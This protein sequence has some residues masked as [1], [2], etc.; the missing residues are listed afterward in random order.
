MG[1]GKTPFFDLFEFFKKCSRIPKYLKTCY[2]VKLDVSTVC[3][4]FIKLASKNRETLIFRPSFLIFDHF[5]SKFEMIKNVCLIFVASL[6]KF[7]EL[8]NI[9]R[10][11]YFLLRQ[12]TRNVGI[13]KHRN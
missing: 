8:R 5:T 11:K 6:T 1:L 3:D 7:Q 12:L 2:K 13:E 4:F 9:D 10:K